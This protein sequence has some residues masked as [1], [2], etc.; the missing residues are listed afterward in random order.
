MRESTGTLPWWIALAYGSLVKTNKAKLLQFLEKDM[1]PLDTIATGAT[2]IIDGVALLQSIKN[3]P[4]T[5]KEI[6]GILLKALMIRN[7]S[8]IDFVTA[9]YPDM[10][11]KNTERNQ[12]AA[13]GSLSVKITDRN[14]RR[15]QQWNKF[16]ACG[17]NKSVLIESFVKSGPKI[18]MLKLLPTENGMLL[19]MVTATN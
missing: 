2:W 16:L 14:Q 17:K 13:K 3:I 4:A 7:A 18:L 12:R 19:F 15:P 5:F 11:I 8:R 1:L 9:R 10:S 6:A